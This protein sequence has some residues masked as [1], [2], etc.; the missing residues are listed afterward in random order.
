M[1][2]FEVNAKGGALVVVALALIA[3]SEA[4]AKSRG[5]YMKCMAHIE[6]LSQGAMM[7]VVGLDSAREAKDGMSCL[8]PDETLT[9]EQLKLRG[10]VYENYSIQLAA[11]SVTA[12]SQVISSIQKF[13]IS[14]DS[15]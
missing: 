11:P 15:P 8:E 13:L 7:Q 12:H 14:L 3:S 2:F 1:N 4:S 9:P 10:A 5:E 6:R